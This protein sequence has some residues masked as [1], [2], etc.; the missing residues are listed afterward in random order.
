VT[1]RPDGPAAVRVPT[2]EPAP[3]RVPAFERAGD[4]APG[5]RGRILV[6]DDE[7][8]VVRAVSQILTRMGFE[9]ISAAGPNEA[10]SRFAAVPGGVD[11]LLTDVVMPDGGGRKLVQQL[12][13]REPALRVLFMSGFTG[14]ESVRDERELPGPLLTKPFTAARLVGAVQD[15]LD[16]V[17]DRA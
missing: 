15:A 9:V 14:H 11:L 2:P 7:P 13:E 5:A 10:T 1:Y 12:R 6:V 17:G 16:G 4:S 3:A 8:M